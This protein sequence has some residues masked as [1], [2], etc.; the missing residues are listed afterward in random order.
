MNRMEAWLRGD[1]DRPLPSVGE[2][3]RLYAIGDIHGRADLLDELMV[4]IAQDD[5]ARG[6]MP[7]HIVLLG[8]LMDRG[9][10]SRLVIEWVIDVSASGKAMHCLKGNHE[11]LFIRAAR[12]EV[13]VIPVFRRAGGLQTLASYG[14]DPA[15]LQAMNDAEIVDWMLHHIPRAHVDFLDALPDSHEVGDYLFV[16]A[17]I[18][19]HVPLA[20]QRSA[21]LRWI[22]HEFLEHEAPHPRMVVHG[23]SITDDV[24]ER[25]NRIGIDT[26]AFRSG[27]LSAI[28]LQGTE[29]WFLQT[30]R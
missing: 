8:D 28:G 1:A 24:D 11:E 2:N 19:P 12:G 21:D 16:H 14:I 25:D 23:H 10:A 7:P 29:R 3:M 27:R 6:I 20:A 18:R 9:P 17:G 26:G 22:R 4:L 30:G 13:G 15:Q 5:R